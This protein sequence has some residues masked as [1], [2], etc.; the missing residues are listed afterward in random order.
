MAGDGGSFLD[1]GQV[2]Q[3]MRE[4]L[5]G[6]AADDYAAQPA[7]QRDEVDAVAK[8]RQAL[9]VQH[10]ALVTDDF[11]QKCVTQHRRRPEGAVVVATG[12]LQFRSSVGWPLRI[13]AQEVERALRTGM[14]WLIQSRHLGQEAAAPGAQAWDGSSGRGPAGC[15]V[16]NAAS[17]D[18]SICPIEEYQKMG[19]F[20]MEQATDNP[21]IQEQGIALIIDLAGVTI[22]SMMRIMGLE[23]IR[24][25][26]LMWKGAFPCRLRRIW[27]V[28]APRG[29]RPLTLP[30]LAMLAPK[31]RQRIRFAWR[32][33]GGLGKLAQDLEGGLFRL[34]PALGGTNAKFDWA[35][36][37]EQ[38]LAQDVEL[39]QNL[40]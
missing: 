38:Y 20:L 5:G 22:S 7:S 1:L 29:S 39:R 4:H 6:E 28:D 37:V 13:R 12:F 3:F 8:V 23:D 25:G 35:A 27:L 2:V 10:R 19:S 14:H 21:T 17:L 26:V 9:A 32:K 16:Y 18:P 15:L 36:E 24:R 30:M 34:P 11:L 31:V 33:D 40:S